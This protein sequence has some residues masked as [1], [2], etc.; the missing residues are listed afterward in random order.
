MRADKFIASLG[1]LELEPTPEVLKLLGEAAKE[2]FRCGGALQWDDFCEMEPE[3]REV[4]KVALAA[5]EG[6]KLS[7]ELEA[8]AKVAQATP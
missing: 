2:F 3:V 6:E 5:V 8:V 4:F 1:V 7:R